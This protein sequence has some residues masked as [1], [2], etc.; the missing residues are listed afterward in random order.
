M[1]YE[2]HLQQNV[3]QDRI[4]LTLKSEL[5]LDKLCENKLCLKDETEE[6][7]RIEEGRPFLRKTIRLKKD[8]L[9]KEVQQKLGRSIWA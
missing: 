6:I 3:F 2:R 5:S 1:L 9:N 7:S 4:R 8:A